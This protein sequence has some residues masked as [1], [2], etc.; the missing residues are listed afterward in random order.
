VAD[1][2]TIRVDDRHAVRLLGI[3]APEKGEAFHDEAARWLEECVDG[4]AVELRPAGR[5]LTD[6]YG[7]A[8]AAVYAAG[9][10]TGKSGESSVNEEILRIGFAWVYIKGPNALDPWYLDA[11]LKAQ[12]R[13]ISARVGVWAEWLGRAP[14]GRP[15][16]LSTRFR[17]H[18]AECRE[19]K[20]TQGRPVE[21]LETEFR[22]G[23]S[24]CRVC[25]PFGAGN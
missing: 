14:A 18:R 4:K 1:G 6:T 11:L 24:P 15:K 3:D 22:R 23:K 25:R 5:E 8:L 21:N 16:L 19:L 12:A 13:A 7:R 10:A 9:K 2:D 20:Q 17:I